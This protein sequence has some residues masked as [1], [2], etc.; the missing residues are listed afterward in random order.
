MVA[1]DV[2]VDKYIYGTVN[3]I[4]P[5]APVPV[6]KAGRQKLLPGGA[7]NVACLLAFLELSV[8]LMGTFNSKDQYGD[9]LHKEL[10]D[11]GIEQLMVTNTTGQTTVKQRLMVQ[12]Q[13]VL[14][15]DW[16]DPPAN[17]EAIT[18]QAVNFLQRV[19]KDTSLVIVSD[20]NK[21]FLSDRLL[22]TLIAL[23]RNRGVEIL[24]DPKGNDYGKYQGVTILTPNRSEAALA[25]ARQINSL[26]DFIE[27]S[28][29]LINK[30]ESK[31]IIITDG[32]EGVLVLE[33]NHDFYHI[34]ALPCNNPNI[35]GAGDAFMAGLGLGLSMA[36]SLLEAACLGVYTSGIAVRK[37][38]AEYPEISE[39]LNQIKAHPLTITKYSPR[40]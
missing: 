8:R 23:G 38:V 31:A 36:T 7:A 11:Y 37:T 19:M 28:S 35:I 32:A 21:G 22:N 40:R 14:R 1:G 25:A 26:Q 12:N 13:M 15:M 30:T 20:Y 29:R 2:M 6:F 27:V 24:V 39:I 16:E 34:P 4:C 17:Q 9:F 5:E 18:Q 3:R 10:A 33:R